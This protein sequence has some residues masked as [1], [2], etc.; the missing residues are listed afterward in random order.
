M[1]FAYDLKF[2]PGLYDTAFKG[3]T[4]KGATAICTVS[5]GG[6]FLSFQD[7][8]TKYSLENKDFYR[9]LQLRDYFTKEIRSN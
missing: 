8:K 4:Q 2:K 3:W 7:L 6:Q 5:D 9:Y 1:W